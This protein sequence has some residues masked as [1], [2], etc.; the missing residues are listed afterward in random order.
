MKFREMATSSPIIQGFIMVFSIKLIDTAIKIFSV[1]PY[2]FQKIE[3]K[4]G[5][6]FVIL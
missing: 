5:Y 6:D 1:V 3:I 2:F 4:R